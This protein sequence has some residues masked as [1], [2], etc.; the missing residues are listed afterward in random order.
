MRT[1]DVPTLQLSPWEYRD[2][3]IAVGYDAVAKE[4]QSK[5]PRGVEQMMTVIEKINMAAKTS[6]AGQFEVI[7]H[8]YENIILPQLSAEFSRQLPPAPDYNHLPK[9]IMASR[10]PYE[11][12]T[13]TPHQPV[14]TT[15]PMYVEHGVPLNHSLVDMLTP[16][17][18]T[19]YRYNSAA[20]DYPIRRGTGVLT[21]HKIQP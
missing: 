18:T 3:E 17:S 21:A 14:I 1:I 8:A 9:A 11:H 6:P 4:A 10:K 16:I 13:I 19:D 2:Y 12:H 5:E 20:F 15:M 7:G